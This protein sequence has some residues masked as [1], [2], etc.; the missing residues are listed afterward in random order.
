M[1]SSKLQVGDEL[2]YSI[3]TVCKTLRDASEHE[4]EVLRSRADQDLNEGRIRLDD[5]GVHSHPR[6]SHDG[7][8]ERHVGAVKARDDVHEGV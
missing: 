8:Y 7:L 3:R 5:V 1:D 2:D 6:Q 4:G